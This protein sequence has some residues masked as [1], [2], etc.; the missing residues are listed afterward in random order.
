MASE[1][2]HTV[3]APEEVKI[4]PHSLKNIEVCGPFEAENDWLIERN[5]IM[6]MATMYLVVPNVIINLKRPMV[7]VAN[8]TSSPKM[9]RK[10]EALGLAHK[11]S[12][13][14]DQ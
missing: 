1:E 8:P 13:F 6:N 5:L 12:E 2:E 14:F 4:P 3:R 11:A 10:G 7:P 9:I